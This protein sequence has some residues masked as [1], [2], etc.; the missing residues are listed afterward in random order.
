MPLRESQVE[1]IPT[2]PDQS[3]DI[4]D[5][6]RFGSRADI[7]ALHELMNKC[8]EILKTSNVTGGVERI[9]KL[10]AAEEER[11]A[12][13]RAPLEEVAKATVALEEV[14]R[15]RADEKSETE[16]LRVE[17]KNLEESLNPLPE[18]PRAQQANYRALKDQFGAVEKKSVELEA[19]MA[20][21]QK[22]LEDLC[23][24][25]ILEVELVAIDVYKDGILGRD[26]WSTRCEVNG[27]THVVWE[28]N[29]NISDNGQRAGTPGPNGDKNYTTYLLTGTTYPVELAPD[30]HLKVAFCG[31]AHDA[32]HPVERTEIVLTPESS[33]GVGGDPGTWAYNGK[34]THRIGGFNSNTEYYLYFWVRDV[35][36]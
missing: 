21:L 24:R 34:H 2:L 5:L 33:W 27:K 23:A 3:I 30:E 29:P 26:C 25:R 10:S 20:L 17:L 14:E 8:S 15:V 31:T 11:E 16:R 18:E 9:E 32:N 12:L 4:G 36:K 1:V 22:R 28:S 35:A 19:A 13:V 7:K 6:S